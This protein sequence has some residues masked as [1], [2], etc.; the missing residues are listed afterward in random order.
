MT[1]HEILKT[2]Y[3]EM[4]NKFP[5]GLSSTSTAKFDDLKDY[6]GSVFNVGADEIYMVSAGTRPTNLPIRLSQ[7]RQATKYT[8]LGVGWVFSDGTEDL[9]SMTNSVATTINNYAERGRT[10]YG[11]ILLIIVEKDVPKVVRMF[12]YEDNVNNETFSQAF[13]EADIV[14]LTALITEEKAR[15]EASGKSTIPTTIGVNRIFFGPPGTGKST[16]VKQLVSGST[17][18]RTQFHPEYSHTDL[19][20]G[21]RPVV[22]YELGGKQILGHDGNKINRPVNYFDF[23][24]GPLIKSLECAFKSECHVFLVIEEINRGDCA[25]IFGDAFQLLDRNELGVSEFGVTLKPEIIAYFEMKEVN[26][27]LLGDGLLYLPPNFSL[28][29][30]MNTSDQSLFPMDSAFKRRWE[31]KA[32]PI[33]FNQ[34][35]NYTSQVRPFLYDGKTNWDWIKLLECININIV[36]DQMED[37]QIGPWFIKPE[38]NGQVPW[39]S[40]LNK[41]LFYLWHDVFKDEQLSD[42]SPFKSNGFAVFS[43]VQEH[44]QKNGLAAGFKPEILSS[45]TIER[46]SATSS[47]DDVDA[48][49][50]S[51]DAHPPE[52]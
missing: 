9:E 18:F 28:L 12:N 3:S 29:A 25:A 13:P 10:H 16:E 23:V 51:I 11:S 30:T 17:M 31:W 1:A 2:K 37:K 45:I 52:A 19:I 36:S 21:Y 46:G 40:F 39:D 38:K 33:N 26:Y 8:K 24:S 50:T 20:G 42:L 35:L 32:C 43:Q 22:G 41:G 48:E 34:I 7:G 14:D 47:D 5:K 15:T 4:C 6:F 27:D 49:V 44:I